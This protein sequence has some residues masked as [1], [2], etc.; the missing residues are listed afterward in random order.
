MD[1]IIR[2][3]LPPERQEQYNTQLEQMNPVEMELAQLLHNI[4]VPSSRIG[5]T[6]APVYTEQAFKLSRDL[7]HR[8][9]LLDIL[10]RL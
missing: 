5:S 9:A 7:H 2:T 3:F 8:A 6:P 1:K 10:Q 4:A